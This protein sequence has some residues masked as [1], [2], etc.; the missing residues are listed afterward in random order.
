[1]FTNNIFQ[2]NFAT[3]LVADIEDG[4]YRKSTSAGMGVPAGDDSIFQ[5]S[6]IYKTTGLSRP[7]HLKCGYSETNYLKHT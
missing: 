6:R 1:M 2:Y 5:F 7:S 3:L 4:L